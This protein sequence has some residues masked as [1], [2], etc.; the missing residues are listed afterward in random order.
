MISVEDALDL[1][2]KNVQQ[3]ASRAIAVKD[4]LGLILAEDVA[5]PI[6]MPPFSQSAMDGYAVNYDPAIEMYTV[7]AEIP[8]GSSKSYEL[9]RGEATRIFTGGPVPKSANMVIRQED[10]NVVGSQISFTPAAEGANIRPKGEQIKTGEIA[11]KAGSELNP[12]AIGY[13][14]TL[15]IT[16]V[17]VYP[18]PRVAILTTGNELVAPGKELK[19][20]QIYESNSIML[21]AAFNYY[22]FRDIS[23]VT[24]PDNYEDTVEA[25]QSTL[26]RCNILVLSG[27]ISVGDYDF[28]GKALRETGVKE[29]FYKVK[30]KPGKPIFFGIYKDK[31]VFA[32]P[33]NPAAAMTSFYLYILP[34]LNKWTGG[35]FVGCSKTELPLSTD[36]TRKG[37]RTEILKAYATEDEVKILGAQSSAML[38]SFAEANALVVITEDV[39]HVS[40]GQ[41]V[42]TLLL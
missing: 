40:K 33:G 19:Y 26:N 4:A 42:V 9:V 30:Q 29:V 15:G 11:M 16:E 41:F 12:A 21:E 10:V 14:S 39:E 31:L 22:G 8:A 37:Q 18:R 6:D 23:Q 34:T 7:I 38:G 20:G 28:V 1:V 35:D 17:R 24:I 3:S 36:Y 5:S 27:G 2:E 25:I 13:L 32:L